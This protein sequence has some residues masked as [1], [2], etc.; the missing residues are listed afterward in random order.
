M[1]FPIRFKTSVQLAPIDLHDDFDTV[2]LAKLKNTLE[3]VCSRHGYIKG[4][5][6]QILKR[7]S[8]KLIKQHFNGY[9]YFT[10]MCRAEVC[11]PANDFVVQAKVVNKNELGICAESYID[12]TATP[13]IDIIVPKKTAGI[14]SEVDVDGISIGDE[15]FV[16]VIG[17]RFQLNDKKIS[18]IGK[19]VR[20]PKAASLQDVESIVDDDGDGGDGGD[21]DGD[22]ADDSDEDGEDSTGDESDNDSDE[23]RESQQGGTN[24]FDDIEDVKLLTIS[25]DDVDEI[26]TDD[27]ESADDTDAGFSD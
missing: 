22:G 10:V 24:E 12:G 1:F 17:K 14:A 27:E 23:N 3:G 13:V 6:L 4:G 9:V 11:N 5:S 20:N 25:D 21:G 2:I 7:S 15:I 19:V 18:I 16:M 8:G 26:G